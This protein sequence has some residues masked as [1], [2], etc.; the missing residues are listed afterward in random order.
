MMLEPEAAALLAANGIDYV[1]HE[2]VST[3]AEAVGAATR[4]GYPVVLK[5]VSP[6]VVHKSDVGGVLIG[7]SDAEVVRRG[8]G[9]LVTDVRARMPQAHIESVLVCRQVSHGAEIDHRGDP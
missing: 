8:F 4:I 2:V 7:L 5:L 6:D 3:A 1:E 9:S